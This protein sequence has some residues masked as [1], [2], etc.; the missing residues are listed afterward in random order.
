LRSRSPQLPP[1][2]PLIPDVRVPES[3]CPRRLEP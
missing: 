1:P 2:G 3:L